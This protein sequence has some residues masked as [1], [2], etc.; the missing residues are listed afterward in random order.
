[1]SN[2]I[3]SGFT[4]FVLLEG[5]IGDGDVNL[6]KITFQNLTINNCNGGITSESGSGN[7]T[8]QKFYGNP[9][10]FLNY[11]R[12]KNSELFTMP[13][14]KGNPDFRMNQNN[15]IAIGN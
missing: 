6:S 10:F 15:A 5:N 3:I 9:L 13:N 1:M 4:P 11:T 14:I 12:L 2:S 8:I 7:P